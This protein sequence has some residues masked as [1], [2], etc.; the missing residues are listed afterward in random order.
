MGACV[1]AFACRRSAFSLRRGDDHPF[2]FSLSSFVVAQVQP[3]FMQMI[4]GPLQLLKNPLL[5][6]S[7]ACADRRCAVI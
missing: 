1:R 3:L 7:H 5:H 6:V 4:S 2:V